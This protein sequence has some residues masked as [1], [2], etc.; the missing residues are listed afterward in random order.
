[1]LLDV[2]FANSIVEVPMQLMTEDEAK[3]GTKEWKKALK[4]EKHKGHEHQPG[5][6]LLRDCGAEPSTVYCS[7][8]ALGSLGQTPPLTRA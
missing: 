3:E 6:D 7:D 5:V 1:M 2:K 4:D 8:W